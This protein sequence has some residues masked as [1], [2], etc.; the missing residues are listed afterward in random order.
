MKLALTYN[1]RKGNED[2]ANLPED[3][4][5]EW[6]DMST[7]ESVRDG[8]LKK[9]DTV[10]LIEADKDAYEKF[11]AFSP[12]LVFNMAEGLSGESRESQIP[13]ILE[14]LGIAYTGSG[15]LTLGLCLN[16]ARAKEALTAAGVPNARY[17]IA[18]SKSDIPAS[19]NFPLIAKPLYEGS[20]KGVKNDCLVKDKSA[21]EAKIAEITALYR[22]AAIVEE[23]LPGREF[24]V[25][26]MGNGDTL[27]V[28]PIVEIDY[29]TLPAGANPIYSYEAK[30]IYDTPE[31]PLKIFECPAKL[32]AGTQ[33]MIEDTAKR[34]FNSLD[35]KDWCR[36]DMRLDV[37]GI[38]NVIELNPLPGILPNP[39]QNSCFPKAARASGMDF[40]ALVCGVVDA[41]RKRYGI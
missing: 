2:K 11:R 12:E 32:D 36:I 10:G 33:R 31:A 41:A 25:A 38:A 22:Q 29:S 19:L 35:V 6:D 37:N 1:V 39:E 17:F 5:A 8:L 7:I 26:L 14:M 23:F 9:H 27:K 3:H 34:A 4:Y 16:K 30:W 24:T 13:A 18:S 21:L 15:P 40:S 28:L 20:S